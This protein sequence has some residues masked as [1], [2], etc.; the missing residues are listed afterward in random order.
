MHLFI[1]GDMENHELPLLSMYDASFFS[2]TLL[3]LTQPPIRN[4]TI[5]YIALVLILNLIQTSQFAV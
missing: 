1:N 3:T 4:I 5:S 2:I